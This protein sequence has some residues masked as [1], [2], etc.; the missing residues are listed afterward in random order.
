M[1]YAIVTGASKGIGKEIAIKLA[2]KGIPLILVAR[3]E[4]LLESLSKELTQKY[5]VKT[6]FLA[7]DLCAENGP[8]QLFNWCKEKKYSVN[9][10]VNNAGYGL[11]GRFEDIALDRQLNMMQLNMAAPVKLAYLFI[12]VLK[13]HPKSYILNIS[14]TTAYQAL[15]TLS[16]YSASKIFMVNFSRGLRLE[17]R[18]SSISVTCFSPGATESEFIDN[19]GMQSLKAIAEKYSMKADVVAASAVEAMFK[20]KAEVIPGF[21][22]RVTTFMTYILP[23]LWIEKI[24]A[25]IYEKHL[26]VK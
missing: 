4:N 11:W 26:P 2:S 9:I 16:V 25:G 21:L 13:E 23:K 10:L 15:A 20:R 17:L 19:A 8:L 3:S 18:N 6:D 1:E 24:A 12:P 22:N 7:L 5:K 14:S